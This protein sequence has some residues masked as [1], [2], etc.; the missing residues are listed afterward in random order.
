MLTSNRRNW[1][2]G[3]GAM[4][5]LG[6]AVNRASTADADA[7]QFQ[8]C[9]NTS[10]VRDN[11]KSR[12][13]GQ[14]V[15]IASKAGYDAIEPWIAELDVYLKGGGSLKELG[16]RIADA[17]LKVPSAI[18]FAEW[19]VEDETRR[20]HG[21]ETAKRD[22]DWVQQIGGSRIAAPPIGATGG[23]SVRDD[24]KNS[25]AVIDLVAA[26]DR[27]RALLELGQTMG[28][29]PEV[30]IWGFSKTLRRLGEAFLIAS[31]C[32]KAGGCVLPDVYHLYKGGSDFAGLKLLSG[33]A[34]GIFHVNDY[35]KKDRGTITDADR[36]Y[37][38]D[39]IAPL[40]EIFQTLKAIGYKGYLSLELFNRDY[41]KHDGLTVAKTGLEKMKAAVAK[42]EGVK[43]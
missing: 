28:V 38:G 42:A 31:E 33:P 15:E 5:I 43:G 18:G 39:G 21:L 9:L 2:Q 26:A 6:A 32:G 41:W 37:P 7:S 25:A 36:V 22:M 11:G 30:E 3:A 4:G 29:T 34:I 16:K 19:I 27:Y 13:I 35:P 23:A 12:P 20:K 8:F 40:T 14:L 10:T 1:L 24:P 17:G